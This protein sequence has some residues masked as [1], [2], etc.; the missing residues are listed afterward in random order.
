MALQTT[1]IDQAREYLQRS[2]NR[3]LTV[4]EGLS[5]AQLRFKP[6]PDRWS[7]AENLEHVV[8]VQE[9][10]LG[11]VR[12]QLHQAAA[13]PPGT[14]RRQIEAIVLERVPDRSMKAKAPAPIEPT[15]SW[16][17]AETLERYTRNSSQLVEW[18]ESTPD[19]RE[20]ALE[21]AP[22]KFLTNGAFTMMDGY[23]L[24]LTAAGHE[25]RHVRQIEEVK[26]DPEYPRAHAAVA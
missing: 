23:Q 11:P 4:T 10:I 26:A 17:L 24:L 12:E 13:L 1:E 9:R 7:I 20:H 22:L 14:D 8:I 15:G 21:S 18:L 25:E 16:T 19:L 3:V 6:A 2:R 5:E